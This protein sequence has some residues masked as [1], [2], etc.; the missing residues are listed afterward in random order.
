MNLACVNDM[1]SQSETQEATSYSV[2]QLG[3]RFEL[4]I[5]GD[6]LKWRYVYLGSQ[7]KRSIPLKELVAYPTIT[8]ESGHIFSLLF[9]FAVLA[10]FCYCLVTFV[11]LSPV[12]AIWLGFL[13]GVAYIHNQNPLLTRRVE[14][15]SFDTKLKADDRVS[16]FRGKNGDEFYHFVERLTSEI[17]RASSQ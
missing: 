10:T 9:G 1:N 5:E 15:V 17:E 16:F 11:S 2:R 7:W 8:L 14:W 3:V 6:V 13:T 4:S 12:L